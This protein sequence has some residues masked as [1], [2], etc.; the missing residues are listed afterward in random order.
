LGLTT[1]LSSTLTDVLNS[2]AVF[3][4]TQLNVRQGEVSWVLHLH[5]ICLNYDG[6]AFDLCLLAA[7]AALEE[8]MGGGDRSFE[9]CATLPRILPTFRNPALCALRYQTLP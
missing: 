4:P 3:D 8:F 2:P 1:F 6:N 9:T 5:I 7:I